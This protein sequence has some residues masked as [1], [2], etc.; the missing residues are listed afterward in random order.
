MLLATPGKSIPVGMVRLHEK[1]MAQRYCSVTSL[2]A[3]G[4]RGI[5]LCLGVIGPQGR[6]TVC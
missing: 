5:I 4:M 6:D 1:T 2:K 3:Y